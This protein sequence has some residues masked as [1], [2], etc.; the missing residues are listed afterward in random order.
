MNQLPNTPTFLSRDDAEYHKT[1]LINV[2]DAR[3]KSH[4]SHSSKYQSL[5]E[6][7][8]DWTI[9]EK[10]GAFYIVGELDQ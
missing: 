3:S 8:K 2:I 6:K 10:D 9:E 5:L 1:K 7:T 4:P